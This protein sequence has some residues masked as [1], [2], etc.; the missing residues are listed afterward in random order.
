VTIV[1][2]QI[3]GTAHR[4]GKV[5]GRICVLGSLLLTFGVETYHAAC[6]AF[7]PASKTIYASDTLEQDCTADVSACRAELADKWSAFLRKEGFAQGRDATRQCEMYK[8][9][10]RPGESP[11]SRVRK[12]RDEAAAQAQAA[13]RGKY[14]KV[15]M[16]SFRLD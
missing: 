16:T 2:G 9:G 1:D 12:W 14:T 5:L 3:H 7:D 4:E 15:T 11:L 6:V 8:E 10:S 13:E